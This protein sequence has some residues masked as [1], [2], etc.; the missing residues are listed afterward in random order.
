VA[1]AHMLILLSVPPA[2]TGKPKSGGLLD[3]LE[4]PAAS[5]LH[6]D[7]EAGAGLD[8]LSGL[9]PR[10]KEFERAV[11]T[12]LPPL[13]RADEPRPGDE[14]IL[15]TDGASRGNPGPAAS[16]WA[17]FNAQG[18]LVHE[19]GTLLGKMTNNEAEYGA[20]CEALE[21]I[22]LRLGTSFSLTLRM[23]SELAVKQLK[24]EYRVKAENL[25]DTALFVMSQLAAFNNLKIEH[26]PREQN[27]RADALANRALDEAKPGA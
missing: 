13:P 26:V 7:S 2:T 1:F 17:L 8:P 19:Q 16:G 15:Y 4:E 20:L 27:A 3:K 11:K 21:W 6:A 9:P 10:A 14:L 23:D 18:L 22:E 25:R 12:K 24:G 5:G